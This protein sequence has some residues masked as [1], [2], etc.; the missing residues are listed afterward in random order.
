MKSTRTPR[1]LGLLTTLAPTAREDELRQATSMMR[2]AVQEHLDDGQA[3]LNDL[4]E[5]N[6]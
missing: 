5:A 3:L 4:G 2:D 6:R 1:V